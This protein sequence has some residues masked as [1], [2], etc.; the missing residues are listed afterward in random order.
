MQCESPLKHAAP[1]SNAKLISF[2]LFLRHGLRAP[3]NRHE[4]LSKSDR[5][6]WICDFR[7]FRSTS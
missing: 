4:Y 2:A 7:I 3:I 1:L 5:G 6:T